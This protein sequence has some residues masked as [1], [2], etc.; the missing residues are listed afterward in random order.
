MALKTLARLGVAAVAL[1]AGAAAVGAEE[2]TLYW[3]PG[4]AWDE[5]ASVIKQWEADHPGWTVNWE[6]FQW[7]D[8]R[9]KLIA[10]FAGGNPP[11]LS[12]EPGG[13][14]EEFGQQGLLTPLD[15]YI[16]K[17]GAAMGYP[18]DWQGYTVERN[19]ADGV[20]YGIQIHLTCATLVYNQDML[21]AAGFDKPPTNWDEFKTI[22]A[23]TAGGGKWGFAPNPDYYYYW[24]WIYQAGGDYYDAADNKVLFDSP[25][26]I[27][28][29]QFV[30]DLIHKDKSAPVP[31]VGADYEGPA[32]L[33]TAGRA[34]MIITG[35]WDVSTIRTGAPNMNWDIAPS[36]TDKTQATLAGGTSVMIPKGAK[37][38]DE[39]WDL[40]KRLVSL[41]TEVAVSIA[42]GMT[43]PRKSWTENATV[44]ADPTLSKYGGCLSYA[45]DIDAPLRPTGKSAKIDD[46][47]RAAMDEIM[48]KGAPVEETLH[49]YA[50]QANDLLAQK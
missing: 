9:T 11:D 44:Q 21:K 27:K 19:K 7:P 13:W 17:D 10:D 40:L 25:E 22:A 38:P 29:I 30:A 5:Y 49:K 12:A 24:P 3:N 20:T 46:L 32:K 23:A 4:H 45:R 43:M 39:A 28:A 6:K 47:F 26:A 34:A 2:L 41:D 36:L 33:F 48:Y 15:D 1:V 37:H 50:Q 14:V 35:P 8:M 31:V 16:A 42:H 18:D